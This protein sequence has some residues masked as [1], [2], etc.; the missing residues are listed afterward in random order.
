M[1]KQQAYVFNQYY[2]DFLKKI[3]TFAKEYKETKKDAR[4]IL[5]SIRNNYTSMDKMSDEYLNYIKSTNILD[6]FN[7]KENKLQID[8][9]F[10]EEFLYK[11][12]KI[13]QI[14]SVINNNYILVNF[15]CLL[16]IF[17]MENIDTEKV[18]SI[19]KVLN[20]TEEFNKLL[21][22]IEDETLKS[23]LSLL[24]EIYS[25]EKKA[26]ISDEFTELE[27]SSL[28]KLAKELM[29][30]I[31]V[32]KLQESMSDPNMN[33]LSCLQDPNSEFGK[34][35]GNVSQKMMSKISKGEL[36]H[37]TMLKD[38]LDLSTKI[39][40]L[41]PPEL[42]S[43]LSGLNTMLNQFQGMGMD[44]E[45]GMDGMMDMFKSMITPD[46]MS[47]MGLGNMNLNKSQ[48]KKAAKTMSKHMTKQQKIDKLKKKLQKYK[49]ET[50]QKDVNEEIV[51][52]NEKV[53]E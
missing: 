41:L 4:D 46:M 16:N 40:N 37:Q 19:I 47:S 32:E 17:A 43:Q 15:L 42:G 45:N 44:T 36:D 8:D 25:Q 6:K 13:S 23:R 9:D 1:S 35:L 29:G 39:P 20:K 48:R 53:D 30:D 34:I 22:E 11:N 26:S 10:K 50:K 18:V 14:L 38:A 52:V 24:L 21:E 5:R 3:K 33:I 28:G 27:N 12:I 31:N 49:E 51:D 2:I 7:N